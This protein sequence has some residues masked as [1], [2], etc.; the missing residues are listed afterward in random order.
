MTKKSMH[1]AKKEALNTNVK[2]S[3]KSSKKKDN[4]INASLAERNKPSASSEKPIKEY[5]TIS[6]SPNIDYQSIDEYVEKTTQ[7]LALE[8]AAEEEEALSAENKHARNI[9]IL[10]VESTLNGRY[11]VKFKTRDDLGY[12]IKSGEAVQVRTGVSKEFP[13]LGKA[14]S[15]VIS[16]AADTEYIMTLDEF[17]EDWWEAPK[18]ILNKVPDDVTFKRM[19]FALKK[20]TQLES[21]QMRLTRVCF[22]EEEPATNQQSYIE[23]GEWFN[24]G[25][26][27]EQKDAVKWALGVADIACILGP[28]GTGKTTTLVEIIQQA[29]SQR[30][31]LLVCAPSNTA[32]DNIVLKLSQMSRSNTK[33]KNKIRMIRLGHPA[34]L[35]DDVMKESLDYAITH[36]DSGKIVNDIR[37]DI[38]KAITKLRKLKRNDREER[39]ELRDELKTLRKELKK[40]EKQAAYG[41]IRN[42]QV[43]LCTLAGADD[44]YLKDKKFDLVIIDEAAQ[45]IEAADW[46]ALLKGERAILAGDPFQLPPTILSPEAQR[47]GLGVTLFERLYKKYGD[48]VTRM[49]KVQYRMHN[50]IMN[51]SSN[52]FYKGELRAGEG[53]GEH[54]LCDLEGVQETDET[55]TPL[56]MI[57]TSGCGMEESAHK[58]GES[59]KNEHE[60]ILVKKYVDTL[61]EAGIKG[62][63]ISI[64]SPYMSQVLA[65]KDA[66]RD[67]HPFIEI[68]TVDG[69]QGRENE[70]IIVSMVRSNSSGEVGFLADERRTN[71]AITRAKRHVCII[72]DATSLRTNS[73]LSRMTAYFSDNAECRTGDDY[74]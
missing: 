51:W 50:D 47:Q 26:N 20:L 31:N 57:D 69:F 1:N 12:P 74:L 64:I 13:E 68:G 38:T 63:Q 35:H 7:L 65:L 19:T 61:T 6:T 14:V 56:F 29:V 44:I 52:E 62:S 10:E 32:V 25:L 37:K 43:I 42:A 40:R 36:G 16:V 55:M 33:L 30:L 66:L 48:R 28:P 21:R 8:R 23:I 27:E 17:I 39:S 18:V 3:N 59:I 4:R 71:V 53:I 45:S 11:N 5:M 2:N 58:E 49:L 34:R 70:C 22:G 54:L 72:C 46:I 9:Q 67:E 24:Q 60:V 73:F 15:G 41:E